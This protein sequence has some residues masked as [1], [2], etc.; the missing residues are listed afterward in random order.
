MLTE[1][2]AH[3]SFPINVGDPIWLLIDRHM[4]TIS[5]RYVAKVAPDTELLVDMA[6]HFVPLQIVMH[7]DIGE[8]FAHEN[9][10]R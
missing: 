9:R 4:S 10:R 7:D 1:A 2:T 6:P 8:R 3:T 5:A